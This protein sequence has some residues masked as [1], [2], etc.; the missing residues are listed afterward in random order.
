MIAYLE[1]LHDQAAAFPPAPA[2]SPKPD[3]AN[4]GDWQ[5]A[6]PGVAHHLTI[7]DLPPPYATR[8]S[9]N[10]PRVV[11][12]P[13]GTVL[14]VP[15]GF[16]VRPFVTGLSNPRLMRVAPNGDIFIAETGANRLRVLRAADGAEAPSDNQMFAEDLDRPFGIAFYPP[17]KNPQWIY[18]ANID[19]V[20]R[21]PYHNGDLVASG[22][23]QSHRASADPDS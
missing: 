8:S 11:P 4:P 9:G 20:V 15:P 17:G 22:P 2:D 16:V 10:G 5:N 7:A 1:T 3:G 21:F 14:S 6:A 13:A 12:C 23:P 18:V 19:S